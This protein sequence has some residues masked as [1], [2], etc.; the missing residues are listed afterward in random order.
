M[1]LDWSKRFCIAFSLSL[2]L[3]SV[4]VS[5]LSARTVA[6]VCHGCR[7]PIPV[8]NMTPIDTP[9]ATPP[10]SLTLNVTSPVILTL[11]GTDQTMNYFLDVELAHQSSRQGWHLTITST[12]FAHGSA[13]LP[14]VNPSITQVSARC[15]LGSTCT[16]PVNLISSYPIAVPTGNPLPARVTF[17]SAQSTTGIGNITI[18]VKIAIK[19]LAHASRGSYTSTV[20]VAFVSGL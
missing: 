5:S 15:Q 13:Q 2:I 6:Y 18:I 7:Y 14:S 9:T 8:L 12:P 10:V 3:L 1:P 19:V 17:Y 20:R 4:L 11:R 16:A